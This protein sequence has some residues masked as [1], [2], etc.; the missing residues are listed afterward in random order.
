MADGTRFS[1]KVND[2][3]RVKGSRGFEDLVIMLSLVSSLAWAATDFFFCFAW[4]VG[5][6]TVG[7]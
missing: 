6:G 2:H 1:C 7:A 5:S 3:L 4:G